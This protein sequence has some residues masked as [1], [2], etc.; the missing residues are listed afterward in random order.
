MSI[1]DILCAEED[2]K[3]MVNRMHVLCIFLEDQDEQ[4]R[5]DSEKWLKKIIDET[6]TKLEELRH[7]YN[8]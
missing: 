3:K 1:Y 8:L 2:M 7:T 6:T 5:K 4:K